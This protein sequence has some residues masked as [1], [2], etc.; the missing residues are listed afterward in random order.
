MQ[1]NKIY[2]I[3]AF[4][5][6]E[7]FFSNSIYSQDLQPVNENLRKS[8]FISALKI[9]DSKFQDD[10]SPLINH[11]KAKTYYLLSNQAV[12]SSNKLMCRKISY[13][14]FKK[15]SYKDKDNIHLLIDYGILL[16]ERKFYID[17]KNCLDKA[18][19]IDNNNV[20]AYLNLLDL[21]KVSRMTEDYQKIKNS[22]MKDYSSKLSKMEINHI[23]KGKYSTFI[24]N[25]S[26]KSP[27]EDLTKI[28]ILSK[29]P[30]HFDKDIV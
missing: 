9:I 17:S 20:R 2:T 3:I 8:D 30:V 29:E 18:Y 22:G 14:L 25:N 11:I 27:E 12:N 28:T 10:N 16:R 13:D 7:L 1:L 15:A 24:E 5:I 4:T 6:I 26:K 23:I 19:S 21:L